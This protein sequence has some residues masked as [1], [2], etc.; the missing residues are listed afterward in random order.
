MEGLLSTGP[1]PSS[2]TLTLPYSASHVHRIALFRGRGST[3]AVRGRKTA[4]EK[5]KFVIKKPEPKEDVKEAKTKVE[6]VKKEDKDEENNTGKKKEGVVKNAFGLPVTEESKKTDALIAELKKKAEADAVKASLV[7]GKDLP[8][9]FGKT[10]PS[11]ATVTK[12]VEKKEEEEE[13]KINYAATTV[14]EFEKK[15]MKQFHPTM[16]VNETARRRN[17]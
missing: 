8:K 1:T 10:T 6:A 3:T 16:W 2:F 12:K 13:D 15:V 14:D 17:W 11:T 9:A 5:P 4:E 7:L